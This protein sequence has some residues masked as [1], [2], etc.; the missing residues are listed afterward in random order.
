MQPI[1]QISDLRPGDVL[2]V[3]LRASVQFQGACAL[4]VR[5]IR[6]DPRETYTGWCWINGYVLDPQGLATGRRSLFVRF[7]GL[8]RINAAVPAGTLRRTARHDGSGLAERPST[9]RQARL[10][11]KEAAR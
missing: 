3:G 6:T 7:R 9:P 8:I 2:H 11:E 5:L 1:T 10:S 4:T